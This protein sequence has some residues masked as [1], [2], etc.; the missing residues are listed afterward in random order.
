MIQINHTPNY[1]GVIITGDYYD[2]DELYEALH[3]VVGKE[4]EY[5]AYHDA[6]IRVLGFCYDLRYAKMGGREYQYL[7]HGIDENGMKMMGIVG[8][9]RNLYLSFHV[10]YPEMLFVTMALNNFIDIRKRKLKHPDWDGTIAI[11][12]K[13]QATF[14]NS[15]HDI[16][17][18]RRFNMMVNNMNAYGLDFSN[19]FT[20]YLDFLN[21]R[22]LEWDKDNRLQ[23]ISRIAK[24]LAEHGKE[25]QETKAA[26]IDTAQR[27][28][29]HPS[30]YR[31]RDEYSDDVDW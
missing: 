31:P 19:Y 25:Y 24:W 7:D 26:V 5:E 20:Q 10:L 8:T 15:L 1:A 28:G 17:S 4:G 14:I 23:N 30:D 27:L 22:Y 3:E 11:V 29:G 13:F 12:R 18:E 6:R 16:I 21:I 2:L 9:T